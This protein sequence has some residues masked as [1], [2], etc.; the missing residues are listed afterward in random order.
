[1]LSFFLV[2]DMV[3]KLLKENLF[4]NNLEDLQQL[5]LINAR[6]EKLL[7]LDQCHAT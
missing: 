7:K 1:M 3:E 6:I 4:V 2:Y 5:S